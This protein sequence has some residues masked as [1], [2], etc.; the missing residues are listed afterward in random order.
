MSKYSNNKESTVLGR[1]IPKG[2]SF[3]TLINEDDVYFWVG[4]DSTEM[5]V[6]RDQRFAPSKFTLDHYLKYWPAKIIWSL[7]DGE[8]DVY[9]QADNTPA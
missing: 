5:W 1:L 9:R 7:E 4:M 3:A 6:E 8:V 2:S